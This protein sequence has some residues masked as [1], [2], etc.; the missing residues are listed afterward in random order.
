MEDFAKRFVYRSDKAID[1][2]RVI[3]REAGGMHGDCDDFAI[4]ALWLAE[5]KSML[6]VWLALVTGAA[7]IWRT[8]VKDTG[9]GHAVLWH[10]TYGWIE[11][12][13]PEWAE[14]VADD[15]TLVRERWVIE[16]AM[17]LLVGKILG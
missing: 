7:E 15:L 8:K 11:N 9:A 4:T 13:R 5:G 16:I 2:F 1:S 14:E 6:R 3:W 10:Q 12:G 17:K